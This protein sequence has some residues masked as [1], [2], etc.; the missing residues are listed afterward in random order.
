MNRSTDT[1]I[2]VDWLGVAW[3]IGL[4]LSQ[5]GQV[6]RLTIDPDGEAPDIDP[7]AL[8][9]MRGAFL[10]MSSRLPLRAD[11]LVKEAQLFAGTPIGAALEEAAKIQ[12]EAGDGFAWLCAHVPG[13]AER[14]APVEDSAP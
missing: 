11:E 12:R 9:R 3:R 14:S 5:D 8:R 13:L 2:A 6:W 7:D 4:S 1:A 10:L